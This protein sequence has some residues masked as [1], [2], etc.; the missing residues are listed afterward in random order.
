MV[1]NMTYE[2]TL[3]FPH[4]EQIVLSSHQQIPLRNICVELCYFDPSG[5]H[6]MARAQEAQSLRGSLNLA[7]D[8]PA[9]SP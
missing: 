4:L 2:L 1:L 3:A 7:L 9:T 6:Q 5:L 8:P